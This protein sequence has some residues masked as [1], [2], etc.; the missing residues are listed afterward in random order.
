MQGWM[1]FASAAGCSV[2]SS[3]QGDFIQINVEDL[4]SANNPLIS[5]V[6]NFSSF[7]VS[8]GGARS[9][10]PARRGQLAEAESTP[11]SDLTFAKARYSLNR[12]TLMM[13]TGSEDVFSDRPAWGAHSALLLHDLRAAHNRLL[14][15]P[16]R[17]PA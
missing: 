1:Q 9:A 8:L 2:N 3:G 14:S 17:H 13:M 12:S 4:A 5:G 6:T 11:R 15:S 10:T 16:T 7:S